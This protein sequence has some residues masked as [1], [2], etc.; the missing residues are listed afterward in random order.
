MS[1][2]VDKAIAKGENLVIEYKGE[3]MTIQN[4]YIET[5]GRRNYQKIASKY[6]DSTY[7]LVD[8]RWSPDKVQREVEAQGQQVLI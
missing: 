1:K 4:R 3:L 8:F 5:R 7:D 6:N 2:L